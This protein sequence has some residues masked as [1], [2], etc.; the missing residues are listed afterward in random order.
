VN[1]PLADLTDKKLVLL[2]RERGSKDDRPFAELFRRH[3][4]LVWYLCYRYTGDPQDAED[5][6]QEVFFKAYRGLMTFEGRSSLRTWLARI[7]VNTGR[8]ELRR[9]ARRVVVSPLEVEELADSLLEPGSLEER[10]LETERQAQLVEALDQLRPA[11]REVILLR[12]LEQRSY[13]EVAR[14]LNIGLSAAKMR[15]LRSRIAL[16][17]IYRQLERT[18]E[19][20]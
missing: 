7:A 12:D 18:E 8:N 10:L 2:C 19:M 9:R 16:Q 17:E 3:H 5:L 20:S 14:M 13:Q 11:D 4:R 1:V 6:V 15:V